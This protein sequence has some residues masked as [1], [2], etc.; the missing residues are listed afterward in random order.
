MI[1]F[2][3]DLHFNHDNIRK[4]MPQTRGYETIEDMNVAILH[5]MNSVLTDKDEL[6]IIGDVLMGPRN[7][8]LHWITNLK[9]RLHLI[10]GNHDKFSRDEEEFLF[11]TV[12]DYKVVRHN[13]QSIVCMHYPIEEWDKCQYGRLHLHGHS[14]GN[15][16]RK[17]PNRIDIGWDVF[18]RPVSI[19]EVLSWKVSDVVLHH[20][21]E[22]K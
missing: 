5:S 22:G 13:K 9:G 16:K 21:E 8:G 17:L 15:L 11:E 3:S 1:Y 19:D 12:C 14:H 7:K 10:R 4:Y 6:Y 20:G 2:T 18:Q